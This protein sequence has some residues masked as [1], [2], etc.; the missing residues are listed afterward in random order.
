[1]VAYDMTDDKNYAD[2]PLDELL[3]AEKVAKRNEMLS[4]VLIGFLVGIMLFGVVRNGFGL[5]YIAIPL[6][7]ITLVFR[8]ARIR[9]QTLKRIQTEIS[10]RNIR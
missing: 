6:F 8:N 5:V 7:L 3:A 10:A 2:L 4:A 1:M 9:K